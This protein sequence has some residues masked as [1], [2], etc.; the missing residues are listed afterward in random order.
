MKSGIRKQSGLT[1]TRDGIRAVHRHASYW[2]PL[3]REPSF[4]L[5]PMFGTRAAYLHGRLML[6][7]SAQAEPWRGILVCTDRDR[8]AAL[9]AQWSDL[10][11]HPVLPK[12]LY[13]PE[14][15]DRFESV[16]FELVA[17]ARRGDPRLGVVPKRSRRRSGPP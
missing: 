12:W 7:F 9:I 13:L 6:C 16:A 1:G 3:E 5:R 8:H 2:E 17:A 10:V 4:E 11:P 14:S 15:A